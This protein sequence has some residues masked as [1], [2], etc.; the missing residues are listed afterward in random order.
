MKVGTNFRVALSWHWFFDSGELG[1]VIYK[2][3]C[4]KYGR[5]L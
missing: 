3:L 2:G 4:N 1:V 5:N